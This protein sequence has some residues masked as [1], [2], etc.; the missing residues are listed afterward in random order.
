LSSGI[1]MHD[2]PI[3]D[4]KPA[5][6]NPRKISPAQLE[7]L[8]RS[9]RQFGF[10]DP[11]IANRNGTVIGGHQ[12][13]KAAKRV[14]LEVVPVVYVDLDEVREKALNVALNKI[15][16]EWD[17]PQLARILTELDQ[18]G[19]DVTLTGH[20]QQEIN[21]LMAKLAEE[22][23][24]P[25][26][27]E[28]LPDN[29]ITKIGD[30]YQIGDHRL[31][32]GDATNPEHLERLM[33]G[34]QAHCVFTDPP[35]GIAYK[36]T[37]DFGGVIKGDRVRD[38]DSF[39]AFLAASFKLM[40]R[41]AIDDAGFYV[42][43]DPTTREEFTEALEAAGLVER[44]YLVWA[45]EAFSGL[46]MD[47]YRVDYEPCFYAQ[48]DGQ[49]P[50]WF[51]NRDQPSVWRITRASEEEGT[52]VSLANGLL[53]SAVDE[54]LYLGPEKPKRKNVRHI[55]LEDGDSVI[56]SG[57]RGDGSLWT[58]HRGNRLAYMHPTQKPVG[59]AVRAIRNSTRRQEI[60]LAPFAG[61]GST[62]EAAHDTGRVA[63]LMELD[64]RYCDV[65]TARAEK[66]GLDVH[67]AEP[68]A[69]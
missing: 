47:H 7:Q 14:G 39:V 64:P 45:K 59:L 53:L 61:S 63:Y 2:V 56:V 26:H 25:E 41:H 62:M 20:D 28:N 30:V 69:T 46:G 16:G 54:T 31:I 8:E 43:H 22:S 36:G 50:R 23:V 68:A 11:I 33:G 55:R 51:G 19:F 40:E 29:P 24:E 67:L 38:D 49:E 66:L 4:L 5:K 60:V 52:S 58:V 6:Y 18:E 27:K 21:K 9:I 10:V 37:A 12:R 48:K 34:R 3:G 35:Y 1:V 42:W 13:L 32:C 15:A 65:I 17:E 44:Q 57:N